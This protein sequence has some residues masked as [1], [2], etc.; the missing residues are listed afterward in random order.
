[1]V[2]QT[3]LELRDGRTLH[4]Y[5]TLADGADA[6]LTV[7][8]HHGTPNLGPPPQPLL[9]AAARRG[10]RWVSYDRPGYGGSTPHPGRDVAS[11]AADVTGVADARGVARAAAEA[12]RRRGRP[13]GPPVEHPERAE[14]VPATGGSDAALEVK[15]DAARMDAVEQPAAV[16]LSL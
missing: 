10:I 6:R 12:S 11:A 13:S 3:D 5:D 4:V 15:V 7:F 9:P 8:W 14:G 1:V 16:G 2:T